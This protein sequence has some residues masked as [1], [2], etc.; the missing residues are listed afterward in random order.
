MMA[1]AAAASL[2]RA[3]RPR[4]ALPPLVPYVRDG[5]A[6]NATATT[7]TATNRRRQL[8]RHARLPSRP[9]RLPVGA[10][11][12]HAVGR[13]NKSSPPP[14]TF[15]GR[16]APACR[17]HGGNTLRHVA[18]LAPRFCPLPTSGSAGVG[19]SLRAVTGHRH[20]GLVVKL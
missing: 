6:L 1:A 16:V 3:L 14:P 8:V 15:S 17:L 4:A 18:A 2:P 10:G 11:H 7:T 5:A 19:C 12:R 20:Q 9:P 13:D